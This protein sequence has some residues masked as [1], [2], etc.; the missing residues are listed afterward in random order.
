MAFPAHSSISKASTTWA[1]TKTRIAQIFW[2]DH[3]VFTLLKP[4][5]RAAAKAFLRQ[6]AEMVNL[7]NEG[8]RYD[9][10]L[11]WIDDADRQAKWYQA[12]KKEWAASRREHRAFANPVD[13]G[14][15]RWRS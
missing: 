14:V 2:S 1:I 13:G 6:D 7:Q 3:P 12:L 9:P 4:L 11:L 5:V 10:T 8:L 15:L